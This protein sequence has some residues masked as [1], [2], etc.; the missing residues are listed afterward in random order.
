MVTAAWGHA[1]QHGEGRDPTTPLLAPTL[2][3]LEAR[4]SW[5]SIF[6]LQGKATCS[7]REA[8]RDSRL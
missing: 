1:Q 2:V 6:Q 7:D 4:R 8:K 3:F 5:L